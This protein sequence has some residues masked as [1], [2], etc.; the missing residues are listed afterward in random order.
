MLARGRVP[1]RAP[2]NIV[3]LRFSAI[4]DIVLTAPAREAL[5]RCYPEARIHFATKARFAPLVSANPH[6]HSVVALEEGESTLAFRKRL[7]A[8][9]PDALLDL[10]GKAR[11]LLLRSVVPRARR[12]VWRK[13]RPSQALAVRLRLRPY[14]ADMRIADRYHAAVER[15]AGRA[16][17]RGELRYH[18]ADDIRQRVKRSLAEVGVDTSRSI[19]G[20]APGAMWE[21]KRWPADRYA[22]LAARCLEAGHQVVLT[23][24]PAEAAVVADVQRIAPGA[25]DLGERLTLE[26]LPGLIDACAAFVANDSGPMHIARALGVPTL[27]IFGSTDPGQF[28]FAGHGLMFAGVECAPCSLYGL[29]ACPKG[30]FD[31]MVKLDVETAWA[32]LGRLL[33]A[34]RPSLV[35]G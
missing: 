3:V 18:L 21:T 9:Q 14:H 2:R 22:E 7:Q 28:D 8:L 23:G 11:G 33:A 31:C 4:G 26:D 13:R 1:E 19:V 12:V 15:L 32:Q 6:V 25:V 35:S 5:A 16:L 34:G 20:M 17:E 30:H 24:S 27:A 10:H 29:S